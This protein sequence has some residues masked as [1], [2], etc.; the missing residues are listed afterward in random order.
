MSEEV[1]T[2][3]L[4]TIGQAAVLL[5]LFSLLA[6]AS[7][8]SVTA[9]TALS[10]TTTVVL[11]TSLR[12]AA[13]LALNA[14]GRRYKLSKRRQWLCRR[15]AELRPQTIAKARRKAREPSGECTLEKG[16]DALDLVRG[17]VL[18]RHQQGVEGAGGHVVPSPMHK[19]YGLPLRICPTCQF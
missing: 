15:R 2:F 4:F 10:V 11:T 9:I 6:A 18:R 14:G 17:L 19:S 7:T 5:L 16:P 1:P 13:S 3:W 8:C 12:T